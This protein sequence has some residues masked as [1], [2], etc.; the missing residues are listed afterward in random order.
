MDTDPVPV[1]PLP[2]SKGYTSKGFGSLS[3]TKEDDNLFGQIPREL[4]SLISNQESNMGA[5]FSK[6]EIRWLVSIRQQV[7]VAYI[8]ELSI[9][10]HC[11][12]EPM[13]SSGQPVVNITE[14]Y[15]NAQPTKVKYGWERRSVSRTSFVS[16]M[17][18]LPFSLTVEASQHESGTAISRLDVKSVFMILKRRFQMMNVQDPVST[19]RKG[20]LKYLNKIVKIYSAETDIFVLDM[21]LMM[22][23]TNM[24]LV[25]MLPYTSG[26]FD[27]LKPK[28]DARR[29]GYIN[30]L[31]DA[32]KCIC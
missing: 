32:I 28:I 7:S 14:L 20:T 31:V 26:T 29:D 10:Q 3:P 1:E 6:V 15:L 25:I 12:I 24:E 21:Y 27:S 11:H 17:I 19:A 22:C 18:E 8:A 16:G 2:R 23:L 5:P 4:Y 9:I 13:M 30:T